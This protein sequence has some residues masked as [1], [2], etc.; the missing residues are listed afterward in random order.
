MMR[1]HQIEA[2]AMDVKGLPE[3]RFA[4]GRALDMPPRPSLSPRTVPGGLPWLSTFP[5]SKV[6]AVPFLRSRPAPF[7]LLFLGIAVAE[8]AVAGVLGDVEEDVSA[9][10]VGEPFVDQ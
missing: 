4:H 7:S 6:P 3:N 8:L 9:A 5:Q 10:G 1:E 2:A